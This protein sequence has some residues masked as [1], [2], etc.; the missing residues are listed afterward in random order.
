MTTK[1]HK[2]FGQVTV[3]AQDANTT[4]ILIL[5]TGETKKLFNQ[6][7]NLSDSPFEILKVKKAKAQPIVLTK[8]EE[9]IVKLSV[10]SQMAEH[11]YAASLFGEAKRE[12]LLNKSKR[13]HL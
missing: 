1:F 4:T 7:A 8:E 11:K 6:F 12:Y 13:I 10:D 2:T 5:K 3:I 9:A